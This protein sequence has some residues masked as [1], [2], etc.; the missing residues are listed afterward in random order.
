MRIPNWPKVIAEQLK[1]H[2]DTPFVWGEKDCCL[3]VADIVKLYAG[4]DIAADFRGKYKTLLGSKKA[5]NRYGKGDIKSTI[6]TMLPEIPVSE[7]G[8]GDLALVETEA[9]QSLAI[10]FSTRA[11]AMAENGM[12]ALTMDKV[13]CSWRVA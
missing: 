13:I 1:A 12:V 6:D 5:L 7:A 8:R 11:W 3:A 4:F 10:L 9:G 2:T